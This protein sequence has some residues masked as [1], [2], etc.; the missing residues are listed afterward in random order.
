MARIALPLLDRRVYNAAGREV[1]TN[2][3]KDFRRTAL[4][5]AAFGAIGIALTVIAILAVRSEEFGDIPKGVTL[6]DVL[7]AGPAWT[8]SIGGLASI[9]MLVIGA[10]GVNSANREL[11]ER[12]QLLWGLGVAAFG[13]GITAIPV[14]VL[15]AGSRALAAWVFLILG[16]AVIGLGLSETRLEVERDTNEGSIEERS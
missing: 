6:K 12:S 1:E 8:L 9:S 4:V 2:L 7:S 16:V 13:L 5:C 11:F 14:G 15:V 3:K 10:L